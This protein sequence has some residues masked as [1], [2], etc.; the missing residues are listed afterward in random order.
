MEQPYK[1][2]KD[3]WIVLGFQNIWSFCLTWKLKRVNCFWNPVCESFHSKIAFTGNY[4]ENKKNTSIEVVINSIYILLAIYINIRLLMKNTLFMR[5][6]KIFFIHYYMIINNKKYP[7]L[8]SVCWLGGGGL[9]WLSNQLWILI[10]SRIRFHYRDWHSWALLYHDTFKPVIFVKV[11]EHDS[12]SKYCDKS[13]GV[14]SA[15]YYS[16][17]TLCIKYYFMPNIIAL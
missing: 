6:S 14:F 3:T 11:S 5:W 2:Q 12:T 16:T 9:L 4:D 17:V 8:I 7:K 1:W 15:N 10:L 13:I